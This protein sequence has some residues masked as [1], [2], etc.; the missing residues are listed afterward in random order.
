M[1]ETTTMPTEFQKMLS[2]FHRIIEKAPPV[3]DVKDSLEKLNELAKISPHLNL[4]QK[5][6]VM[7]RCKNYI[8]GE[9]GMSKKKQIFMDEHKA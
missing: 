4:R 8:N 7:E 6:A 9:Y 5:D 2:K 3:K 1:S